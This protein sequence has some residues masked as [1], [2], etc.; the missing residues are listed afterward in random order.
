M[1]NNAPS[2]AANLA[3]GKETGKIVKGS[4]I[5]EYKYGVY[6]ESTVIT[7]PITNERGQLE[8]I[9]ETKSGAKIE[10]MKY[11]QSLVLLK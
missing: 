6:I 2:E 3:R 5:R 9:S 1:K 10:Y 11:K 8:F 7:E 4:V